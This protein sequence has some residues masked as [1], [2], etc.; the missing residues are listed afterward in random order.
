MGRPLCVCRESPKIYTYGPDGPPKTHLC[1]QKNIPMFSKKHTYDFSETYLCF[2]KNIPMIFQKHTYVFSKTYL[3]FFKNI[4]M[5][6]QKHT[7]DFSETYVCFFR[8]IGM[9]FSADPCVFPFALCLRQ[10]PPLPP[11]GSPLSRR[12]RAFITILRH[13]SILISKGGARF[14]LFS[15]LCCPNECPASN[16]LTT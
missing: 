5:F 1:F 4:P 11:I 9:F 2:S 16:P 3:C 10:I 8:D 15:Q 13:S 12:G 14:T 7:Y 6:F